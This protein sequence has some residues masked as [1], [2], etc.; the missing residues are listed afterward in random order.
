MPLSPQYE[1]QG[2]VSRLLPAVNADSQNIDVAVR[3][4]RYGEQYTM[5]TVRKSHVLADEGSYFVANNGQSGI[6]WNV[7]TGWVTTTPSITIFN[8][9]APGGPRIYLDYLSLVTTAAGSSTGGLTVLPA[10]VY[11]DSGNRYS[12]RHRDYRH[13]LPQFRLSRFRPGHDLR[14]R[15]Y[16]DGRQQPKGHRGLP[17]SASYRLSDGD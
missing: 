4:A 8:G 14:G 17:L 13:Q 15:H 2:R 1:N 7:P 3:L 16:S 11:L 10:A 9:N 5:S 12:C 6:A